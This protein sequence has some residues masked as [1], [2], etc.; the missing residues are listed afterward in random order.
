MLALCHR[1]VSDIF[2]NWN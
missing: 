2:V 1:V